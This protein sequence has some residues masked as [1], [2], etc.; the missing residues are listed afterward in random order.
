MGGLLD[1][2]E[3][4]M[5]RAGM[6]PTEFPNDK[7]LELIRV[8]GEQGHSESSAGWTVAVF[9]RLAAYEPIGITA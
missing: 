4:E 9:S 1:H 7:V 2:A 3:A 6:D 8:L 5:A